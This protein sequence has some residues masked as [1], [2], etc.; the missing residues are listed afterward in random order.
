[1]TDD[2]GSLGYIHLHGV[3]IRCIKWAMKYLVDIS[4]LFF[5]WNVHGFANSLTLDSQV[6]HEMVICANTYG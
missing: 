2:V 4:A 3:E 6:L 5:L 1:M